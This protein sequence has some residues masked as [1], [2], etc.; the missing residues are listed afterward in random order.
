MF[1]DI[2]HKTWIFNMELRTLDMGYGTYETY[3]M[4]EVGHRTLDIEH[5]TLEISYR[6]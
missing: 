5:W 6:I 4:L 3:R 2:G 1:H